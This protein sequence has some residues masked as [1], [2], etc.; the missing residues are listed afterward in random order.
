M[1]SSLC[2]QG[3]SSYHWEVGHLQTAQ[4]SPLETEG[5]ASRCVTGLRP[6][7]ALSTPR[8]GLFQTLVTA[9]SHYPTVCPWPSW[10][11]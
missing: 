8:V 11:L 3:E 2:H 5:P 9:T 7:P 10:G 1:T 4:L 6:H